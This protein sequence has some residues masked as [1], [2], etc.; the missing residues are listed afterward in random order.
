MK[1]RKDMRRLLP[2]DG[3]TILMGVMAV[4]WLVILAV[5]TVL[6]FLEG[7][8]DRRLW[9]IEIG[10]LVVT[11]V[12]AT[13]LSRFMVRERRKAEQALAESEDR[14]FSLEA[15]VPGII[16]RCA[17]AEKGWVTLFLSE[18]AELVTGRTAAELGRHQ[19]R[20][21]ATVIHPDDLEKAEAPYWEQAVKGQDY[22]VEYRILRKDGRI[23]WMQERGRGVLDGR[24]MFKWVDGAVFDVTERKLSEAE[25]QEH[26]RLLENLDRV[27]RATRGSMDLESMMSGALDA[28]REIYG[29]DR[30]W[31]LYPCDPEAAFWEVPMERTSEHYPGAG[32]LET[33]LPMNPDMRRVFIQALGAEGPVAYD[34]GDGL[35]VPGILERDFSVKAQL[36]MVLFPR[37]GKPWLLGMHQCGYS[38]VWQEEEQQL[39]R[40]IGRRLSDA[41]SSLLTY[42]SLQES[43]AKFR[44]FVENTMLGVAVMQDDRFQ[45][46]NRAMAD[47]F[48]HD[49]E[50]LMALEPGEVLKLIHPEDRAFVERQARR[51]Q[52]G[53]E[54]A[55][56]NYVF[57]AL[58]R[59]GGV[60]WLEI[61]SKTIDYDGRPAILMSLLNV[62]DTK[63][64]QDELAELNRNLEDVIAERTRDLREKAEELEA[65]NKRLMRL[66]E[67]KSALVTTVAH[68]LRTPLTSVLGFAKIMKRD[69]NRS[70]GPLVKDDDKLARKAARIVSNL[71][72]IVNEGARLT[73]LM[74]DFLDL[75]TIESGRMEWKDSLVAA[76]A[77]LERALD[78]IGE[79]LQAKPEVRVSPEVAPGLP[80]LYMDGRR[81]EQVLT[82]LLDNAVKFT[83]RGEIV[84]R[85]SAKDAIMRMEV[86][87]PGKGIPKDELENIF[88]TFYQ[89]GTGDTLHDTLK[90]T[91][92]G[93]T[94]ARQIVSHYGG[95]ISVFSE[96]G[97]GSRFVVELPVLSAPKPDR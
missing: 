57:R 72:I 76:P 90:G 64:A 91:G 61:Y 27:D 36:V 19:S 56:G 23:R 53:H 71:E 67:T 35:D 77:S 81:L 78:N 83:T 47:V 13:L 16:F 8:P 80:E 38:R 34:S 93:L 3:Y 20:P 92:L 1:A 75:S 17:S 55:V 82:H 51:K 2:L 42:R 94:I 48:G 15:N 7:A 10:A 4:C 97:K 22:S 43:E 65:A 39:F 66:D 85:V 70:F 32:E 88:D 63:L 33:G 68:D 62:T 40:E 26:V 45:F 14:F 58:D 86:D 54:D 12:L 96:E 5:G 25:Q 60:R 95:A 89:L 50:T 6:L 21:L 37:T 49:W 52:H 41:L 29:S 18:A 69:F 28:M 74:D 24:G 79:R 44:S 84:V 46:G 9:S 30:A 87:D 73:K 31:L 11:G 59:D